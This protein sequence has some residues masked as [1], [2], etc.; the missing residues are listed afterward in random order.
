M[1]K[2]SLV[3]TL[4]VMI[5]IY[6]VMILAPNYLT[7]KFGEEMVLNVLFIMLVGSAVV[8]T[9]RFSKL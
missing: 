9:Y 6:L 3:I 7:V 5:I 2:A 1:K 8:F 4:S